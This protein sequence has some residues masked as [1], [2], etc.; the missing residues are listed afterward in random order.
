MLIVQAGGTLGN[1][2]PGGFKLAVGS[3]EAINEAHFPLGWP[4]IEERTDRLV[5][6]IELIRKFWESDEFFDFQG[7]YFPMKDVYL[8]TKPRP[9]PPIYFSDLGRKS[10]YLAGKVGDHLFT[11]IVNISAMANTFEKC[12]D[13]IFPNF[14]VG[15]KAAG[16]DASKME[17]VVGVFLDFEG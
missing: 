17:K 3:G 4:P 2:Y 9:I 7:K 10:A 15:A 11:L 13:K 8:Y 6:G 1:M 16:K 14:D 5:E 12:R